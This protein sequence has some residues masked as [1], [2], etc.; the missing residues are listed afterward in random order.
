MPELQA[1]KVTRTAG[2]APR[3][4]HLWSYFAR[5]FRMRTDIMCKH[6]VMNI[7]HAHC[8]QSP[9]ARNWYTYVLFSQVLGCMWAQCFHQLGGHVELPWLRC[10]CANMTSSK[11]ARTQAGEDRTCI[12]GD[13]LAHRQTRSSQYSALLSVSEEKNVKKSIALRLQSSYR[14][15][16]RLTLNCD[17]G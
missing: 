12:S 11:K 2:S 17:C 5:Q 15:A 8:G 9:F 10:N 6:D 13:M 3:C 7:Q 1:V 4:C 14:Y 16:L